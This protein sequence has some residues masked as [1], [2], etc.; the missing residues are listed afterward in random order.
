[1]KQLRKLVSRVSESSLRFD[2]NSDRP[3]TEEEVREIEVR[4]NALVQEN[5]EV[6]TRVM[7]IDSAKKLGARALFGEKYGQ[8]VRVVEIGPGSLELCG[9]T[10]TK[11]S[12]NIG[13]A[14]LIDESSISAGVRRIEMIVGREA[15]KFAQ[16]NYRTVKSVSQ[17]VNCD[18]DSVAERVECMMQKSRELEKSLSRF[19][20]SENQRKGG[21]LVDSASITKDGIK[22]VASIVEDASPKELRE[23]ADDLRSRLDSGCIAL[24]SKKDGKAIILVAITDSLTERFNAGA[25]LKEVSKVLGSRGGGRKDMAQAGGGDPSKLEQSLERFQELIH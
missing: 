5:R 15:V 12:G 7:S 16:S 21:T 14:S 8:M 10:H 18:R 20:Q 6:V 9:G 19:A 22:I 2:F 23:M 3:L 17:V 25:L 24:G 11:H 4:V 13:F 1:M